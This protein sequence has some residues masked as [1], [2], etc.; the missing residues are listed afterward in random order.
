MALSFA[1]AIGR[2]QLAADEV[3]AYENEYRPSECIDI[4]DAVGRI[5]LEDCVS[6][7]STPIHDTSAMDG[8]AI[9][10]CATNNASP[11]NP[12]VFQV[13]GI[14]TPGDDPSLIPKRKKADGKHQCIEIMTGARFPDINS[15]LG[16]LSACVRVEDVS[17][18]MS[19]KAGLDQ[20]EKY[21]AVTKPVQPWANRRMA[22]SDI[23]QSE[24]LLKKGQRIM[25]SHILP[26]ASVGFQTIRVT[27]K[28]RIGIWSTGK[29][30]I[31]EGSHSKDVNGPYLTTA[32][33]E[34]GAEVAFLGH[35]DDQAQLLCREF[36]SHAK[37]GDYDVLITSG[38][39]SAGKF[40]FVR[41]ALDN[42]NADVVFH[43]LNIRPGHPVLF[44][45]FPA[46]RPVAFFGLPGNPGAVAA[47]F[48]FLIVPYL[49]RLQDRKAERPIIAKAAREKSGTGEDKESQH[50]IEPR[51]GVDCF[52]TGRLQ[53]TAWGTNAVEFS[54][55]VN[56]AK[57]Q[58]FIAANCWVHVHAG[59]EVAEGSVVDCYTWIES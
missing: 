1:A 52:F 2:I 48:R 58:P 55:R 31:S 42:S 11:D 37:S 8:Y 50:I 47:C 18:M 14:L 34:Y 33:R 38:A 32:C 23:Q 35:L 56:S 12:A 19:H 5:A 30:F 6:P 53:S 7:T 4:H 22:G 29:E 54:G 20:P 46:K 41:D 9:E 25:T 44:A 57:L 16:R 40:D 39:V 27:G 13:V 36:A 26:L 45:R 24:T 10:A 21:I 43:G 49:R 28:P 3:K 17:M 59:S 51:R 15:S